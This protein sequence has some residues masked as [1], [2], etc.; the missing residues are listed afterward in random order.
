MDE[1]VT[2]WFGTFRRI[3]VNGVGLALLAACSAPA[4]PISIRPGIG[5]AVNLDAIRPPSGAG[6][7]YALEADG[8]ASPIALQLRSQRRSAKVYDYTGNMIIQLPDVPETANLEEV[9]AAL[10]QALKLEDLNIEIRG[11]TLR[12]PVKLRTD[13]RFRSLA[14][15]LVLMRSKYAPHDC[16]AVIGTC[17]YTASQGQRSI[18]L[19][20]ETSEK[21][22]VWKTVTKPDPTKRQSGQPGGAQ[23]LIYSIDRNAVLIDMILSQTDQGQRSSVVFRRQ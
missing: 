1:A 12:F 3:A 2:R 10:A 21:N 18:A 17:R 23:T 13:N 22:G 5:Q 14:S 11:N 16:F 8:V 9:G 6:Y 4:P 15:D 20:A 19:V 7:R